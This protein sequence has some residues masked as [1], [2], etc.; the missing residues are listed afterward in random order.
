MDVIRAGSF[1][2][3]ARHRNI[4]PSS[5]SRVISNLEAELGFRLFQ[6]TTRRLA[7]TEAGSDYFTRIEPLVEE[8]EHAASLVGEAMTSPKGT[9]RVTAINAFGQ[10]ILI[11]LLPEL[12]AQYP[13]LEVELILTEQYLDLVAEQIDLAI[14]FGPHP[15]GNLEASYLM[16]T[17]ALVCASPSYLEGNEPIAR[18]FDLTTH[19]CLTSVAGRRAPW[20][21]RRPGEAPVEIPVQGRLVVSDVTSVKSYALQ[22]L[23][24][25]LLPSWFARKELADGSLIH[26]LPDY[27]AA[28]SSF[29]RAGW[30]VY[31]T[32]RYVPLKLRAMIEFLKNQLTPQPAA[33][34]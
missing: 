9:L 20:L 10:E 17:Q 1:A 15:T 12:R 26:V 19:D 25:G 31:P 21:F 5:V 13:D 24:P 23:G 8:L 3:V 32:R 7:P 22:G 6:R 11:P 28:I 16:P 27:E 18:P 29:D 4:D 34:L 30:L 33:A 14:R 2:D